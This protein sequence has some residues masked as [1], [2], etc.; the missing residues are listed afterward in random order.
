ML[1]ISEIAPLPELLWP[2][3]IAKCSNRKASC[4]MAIPVPR[5]SF[6]K[7]I[8]M[9]SLQTPSIALSLPSGLVPLLSLMSQPVLNLRLKTVNKKLPPNILTHLTCCAALPMCLLHLLEQQI[10]SSPNPDSVP[11]LFH[12]CRFGQYH[13]M[14]LAAGSPACQWLNTSH[15][16]LQ[17]ITGGVFCR[18]IEH[19]KQ[20]AAVSLTRMQ[21][22]WMS[23]PYPKQGR[24]RSPAVRGETVGLAQGEH[25]ER[26]QI[27][28]SWGHIRSQMD[29]LRSRKDWPGRVN[30][31][32]GRGW[33]LPAVSR[34]VWQGTVCFPQMHILCLNTRLKIKPAIDIVFPYFI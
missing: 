22:R 4:V 2:Q 19:T 8:Q 25:R 5:M 9:P 31:K 30:V 32:L 24:C 33:D 16:N 13:R 7:V 11:N 15:S 27:S 28:L 6:F 12:H 17:G 23:Q 21:L 29:S 18:F 34:T 26:N 1:A 10:W 14:G 3:K 20:P